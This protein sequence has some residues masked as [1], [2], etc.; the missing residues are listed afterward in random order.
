MHAHRPD[1]TGGT[2]CLATRFA[3]HLGLVDEPPGAPAFALE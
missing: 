3:V 1:H 2:A